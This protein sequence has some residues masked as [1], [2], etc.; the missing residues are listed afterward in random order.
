M[1]GKINCHLPN[2]HTIFTTILK[3]VGILAAKIYCWK[4][5]LWKSRQQSRERHVFTRALELEEEESLYLGYLIVMECSYSDGWVRQDK[6]TEERWFR[7]GTF[8]FRSNCQ[9]PKPFNY[10]TKWDFRTINFSVRNIC[11]E[12]PKPSNIYVWII[13]EKYLWRMFISV[14]LLSC[15]QHVGRASLT[16]RNK[17]DTHLSP[18]PPTSTPRLCSTVGLPLDYKANNSRGTHNTVNLFFNRDHVMDYT[19][20]G[21]W[22]A[23]SHHALLFPLKVIVLHISGTFGLQNKTL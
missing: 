8:L 1:C 17:D 18:T 14:P 5:C 19:F 20:N 4:W 23:R 16:E 2:C 6:S 9:V 13:L 3:A 12:W 10:M 7:L 15:R 11:R 21:Q 22:S